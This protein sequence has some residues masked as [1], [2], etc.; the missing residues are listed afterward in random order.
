MLLAIDDFA[1]VLVVLTFLE[2]HFDMPYSMSFVN[3]TYNFV[4]NQ[5]LNL[6]DIEKDKRILI[7][8]FDLSLG[9]QN[10]TFQLQS[11]IAIVLLFT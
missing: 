11:N 4:I 9:Y 8:H 1:R 5:K 2:Q 3:N 7:M 10:Y 6:K